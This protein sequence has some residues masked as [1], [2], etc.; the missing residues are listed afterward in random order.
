MQRR[1]FFRQT[2]INDVITMIQ[3]TTG[4]L[5][6]VAECEVWYVCARL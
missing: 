6:D 3:Q 1:K 2:P 4:T 5:L